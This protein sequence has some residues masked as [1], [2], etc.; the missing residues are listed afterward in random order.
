MISVVGVFL[1]ILGI[2]VLAGIGIG[3]LVLGKG[4]TPDDDKIA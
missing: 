4:S 2:S 1:I 3:R